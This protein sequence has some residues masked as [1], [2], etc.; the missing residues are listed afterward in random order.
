MRICNS[1]LIPIAFRLLIEKLHN[2]ILEQYKP[3]NFY[4]G[5]GN[6]ILAKT[7]ENTRKDQQMRTGYM[8]ALSATRL[9]SHL[10][11]H[12][13]SSGVGSWEPQV[14]IMVQMPKLKTYYYFSLMFISW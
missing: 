5:R 13:L 10:S 12:L 14:I 8:L 2:I 11:F 9:F 1:H 3:Y 4:D 6:D 7:I